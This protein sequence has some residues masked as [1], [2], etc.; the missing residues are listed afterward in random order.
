LN[1]DKVPVGLDLCLYKEKNFRVLRL[2]GGLISQWNVANP[3]LQIREGDR[4]KE[5]NGVDGDFNLM[6]AAVAREPMLQIL[7]IPAELADKSK[8]ICFDGEALLQ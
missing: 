5:I 8:D 2:N 1:S 7:V 4:L 6:V 3:D